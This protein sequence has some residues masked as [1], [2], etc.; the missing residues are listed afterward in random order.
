MFFPFR[1]HKLSKYSQSHISNK[2]DAIPL[3]VTRWRCRVLF[4]CAPVRIVL[5]HSNYPKFLKKHV[6][7]KVY[8]SISIEVDVCQNFFQFSFLKF[9][10]EQRLCGFLQ[11]LK[12]DPSITV[13]VKLKFYFERKYQFWNVCLGMFVEL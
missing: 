7:I 4:S 13:A 1:L 8:I 10:A 11:L 9:L 6:T 3:T 2:A 5:I 12:S